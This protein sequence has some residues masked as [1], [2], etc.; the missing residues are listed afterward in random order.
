MEEKQSEAV[1]CPKGMVQSG[2]RKGQC[3]KRSVRKDPFEYPDG[4]CK[5]GQVQSGPREGKCK[6]K[7][8]KKKEAPQVLHKHVVN[9]GKKN[10]Y[11]VDLYKSKNGKLY[12]YSNKKKRVYLKAK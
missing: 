12:Y 11:E 10:A 5:F 1:D 6:M 9:L 3:R 7:P 4:T 2:P 8:T